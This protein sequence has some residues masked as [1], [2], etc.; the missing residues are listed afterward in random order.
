MPI[1]ARVPPRLESAF[2]LA[3]ALVRRQ[4]DDLKR[5]PE[6]GTIHVGGERYVMIRADSMYWGWFTAMSQSFGEQMASEFIYGT[7]REIG[8]NDSREFSARLGVTDGPARLASG[9]VHFAHAGWGFV[10][11][12]DDSH[13]SGDDFF[14]HFSHP[15]SFETEV[16]RNRNLSVD[17]CAC[18]FSAGYSAGWCSEAFG[19][20]VHAR[21][22][23]CLARGDGSCEF[24]MAPTHKLD[25]HAQRYPQRGRPR[26]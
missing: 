10:E 24:I 26:G 17:R 11:I 20:E 16:L 15:N 5:R 8:S 22:L 13:F 2:Q 23:A 6:N 18:F 3:E 4:F 9:P 14:L 12:F 21:E 7:A 25:E 19:L 1:S